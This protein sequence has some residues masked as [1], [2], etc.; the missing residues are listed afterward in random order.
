MPFTL[1][2]ANQTQAVLGK[3]QARLT[4]IFSDGADT[5]EWS[6]SEIKTLSQGEKRALY[7]LNFIFDVEARK[8]ANQETVLGP[9]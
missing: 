5:V 7:L 4:F 3:E 2:V 6:R 1:S 9:T 8:L